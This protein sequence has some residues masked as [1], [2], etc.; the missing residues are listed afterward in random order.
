MKLL[1]NITIII[2][3]SINYIISQ[4]DSS[5]TYYNIIPSNVVQSPADS[6]FSNEDLAGL[7][8]LINV[9]NLQYDTPLNIGT[10]RWW[11]D[12]RL[13]TLVADYNSSGSGVNDTIYVLQNLLVTGQE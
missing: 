8:D 1:K 6:C 10:Q 13:K 2:F 4:C 3:I 5:Y 12:G 7:N 9:N 11:D